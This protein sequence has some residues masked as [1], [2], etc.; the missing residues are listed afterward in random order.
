LNAT[1]QDFAL[2][3]SISMDE[4]NI[5]FSFKDIE[6][7][8]FQGDMKLYMPLDDALAWR[9]EVDAEYMDK[10][11]L[12][13]YLK[14]NDNIEKSKRPWSVV[15]DIDKV[16]W[17]KS[18]AET[19]DISFSSD[20]TSLGQVQVAH[21]V[22]TDVDL[23]QV[24]AD[25]TLHG[26]G[27][28][29]LHLFE[30]K[31]AGQL[32][33]AS[34]SVNTQPDGSLRWQGLALMGGEFGTLMKQAELDKLFREGDMA[35]LFLGHG[36]YKDGEPW[37]REMKG[38]F[39]LRVN[40]GRI[41]EGGTLTRLLAAISLVDLPKYLIFDR[42]DVVGEGLLYG[43]LQVEGSFAGNKLII[44][45]L[46]F[47]SS[48]L[49]AGGTG[50]VDLEDGTM[51]IVL[52]ARPWQNI[53]VFISKIPLLGSI[54]TGEDKSI[55]RKIY[56]IHGPASDAKVDELDAEEAGLPSGGYLED[57][58]TPS[59]WFEPVPKVKEKR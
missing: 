51:D 48:A 13:R 25:F 17:E 3:G 6:T 42:G 34:G 33:Q 57:L 52:V 35:A 27:V 50:E 10:P 43:K 11:V 22:S 16:V 15:A 21:F 55:L 7:S 4:N 29:E 9:I 19:V 58:F 40:D 47:L 20:E 49:D 39:K 26:L 1:H 59:K 8:A 53:E 36:E 32:L 31:G 46:G 18:Y 41:M 12:S 2:K 54:L 28:Y 45:Q 56:R 14:D 23:K 37:W 30:A 38:G 5:N 44:D 24:K